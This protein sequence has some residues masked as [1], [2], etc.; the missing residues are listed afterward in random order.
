MKTRSVL[1]SLGA[2]LLMPAL[3]ASTSYYLRTGQSGPAVTISAGN[4]DTWT[5]TPVWGWDLGG[6]ILTMKEGTSTTDSVTLTLNDITDSLSDI[7][8]VTLPA[9]SITQS[10]AGVHFT[11][12]APVILTAGVTYDLVLSSPA[13]NSSNTD[14]LVKDDGT[15]TFTDSSDG[16]L[17]PAPAPEP[18]TISMLALGGG[19]ILLLVNRRRSRRT[20]SSEIAS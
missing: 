2:L 13:V 6:A 9:S 18:G 10:Y 8:D 14:Y 5:F 3:R 15:V 4:S 19:G 17:P 20:E 7:A 1:V 16:V 12:S 11:F